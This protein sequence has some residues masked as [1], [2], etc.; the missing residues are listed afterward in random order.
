M[1]A[2]RVDALWVIW[3]PQAEL[4]IIMKYCQNLGQSR[5]LS[6]LL[7]QRK[8][9]WRWAWACCREMLFSTVCRKNWQEEGLKAFTERFLCARHH[10][11]P[12]KWSK[13]RAL[14]SRQL[15]QGDLQQ[16]RGRAKG[17]R[18]RGVR[19]EMN[20][21]IW[22]LIGDTEELVNE[23]WMNDLASKPTSLMNNSFVSF[24]K[25]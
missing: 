4:L 24:F 19:I 2:S 5:M 22:W 10:A 9:V 15:K 8:G 6:V 25:H 14:R 20:R 11:R 13:I 18:W 3:S 23:L 17:L 16:V 1:G 7:E 12:K 21:Q